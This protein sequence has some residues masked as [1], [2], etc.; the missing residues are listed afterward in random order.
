MRIVA[1][2]PRFQA[3]FRGFRA[4]MRAGA[5]KATEA[6]CLAVSLCMRAWGC[7]FPW[8]SKRSSRR[9]SGWCARC[10]WTCCAS[11]EL[12]E[13][14]STEA[15]AERE[16]NARGRGARVRAERGGPAPAHDAPLVREREGFRRHRGHPERLKRRLQR[17][18]P[19]EHGRLPENPEGVAKAE[20]RGPRKANDGQ[21]KSKDDGE[22]G[23]RRLLSR[24]PK[25]HRCRSP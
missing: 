23:R 22:S 4:T 19:E 16:K 8:P 24:S 5:R 21:M 3:R 25:A 14:M 11:R 15:Q 7:W 6:A 1:R 20:V 13:V 10:R 12:Q 2:R 17:R 9:R 18:R